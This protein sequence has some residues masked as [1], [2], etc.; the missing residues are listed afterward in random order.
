M[1][2]GRDLVGQGRVGRNE[3]GPLG[4]ELDTDRVCVWVEKRDEWVKES[5]SRKWE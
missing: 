5:L 1:I 2:G 4:L 3:V